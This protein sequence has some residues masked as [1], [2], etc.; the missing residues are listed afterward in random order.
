MKYSLLALNASLSSHPKEI[1]SK[2]PLH[3]KVQ[4]GLQLTFYKQ[5]IS[6][7]NLV[8]ATNT[9]NEL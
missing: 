6:I 7:I 1:W 4:I 2:I 9:L 8:K 3:T 5:L